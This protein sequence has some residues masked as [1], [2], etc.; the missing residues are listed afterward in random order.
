MVKMPSAPEVS[1]PL[2]AGMGGARPE[3][4]PS[5]TLKSV[6]ALGGFDEPTSSERFQK[7]N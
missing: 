7:L 6:S 2:G 1:A 3:I 5:C 4:G